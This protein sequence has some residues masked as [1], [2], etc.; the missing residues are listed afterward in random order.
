MSYLQFTISLKPYAPY[1]EIIIAQ[2]AEWGFESFTQEEPLLNAYIPEAEFTETMAQQLDSLMEDFEAIQTID[3]KKL[4][5]ENWN[6]QWES[7]FEPIPIS[8][9]C[10]IR[11]PFH[12][13]K[14]AF[15]FELIIEPKMSFG[16]GHH[17]TTQLMVELLSAEQLK[18]KNILDMGAGTGILGI[19][20]DRMGAKVVD[21]IDIEEW[22]Y[23]NMIENAER[24]QCKAFNAY[25]G[26]IEVLQGLDHNYDLVI[27]NINKNIL[28]E[29][30]DKYRSKLKAGGALFLSGF[31]ETDQAEFEDYAKQNGLKI[32]KALVKDDWTALKLV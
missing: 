25:H 3:Q 15:K 12:E 19:L 24:N 7:N 1:D 20:A 17:Q 21:A 23:E 30:L 6:Q 31:F 26:G 16:T 9:F 32:A 2:L 14:N 28:F 13:A 27:A 5:K 10:Y 8:D 4:P 11:A 29:Q 18:G 22:A